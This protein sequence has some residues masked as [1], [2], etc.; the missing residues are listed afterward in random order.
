MVEA[1][2]QLSGSNGKR[3]HRTLKRVDPP[4]P[5]KKLPLIECVPTER[6]R[7]RMKQVKYAVP[8]EL[9]AEDVLTAVDA[10]GA[11]PRSKRSMAER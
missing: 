8:D 9:L 1:A 6:R 3:R 11:S 4:D 7:F 2:S 5:L 10:A